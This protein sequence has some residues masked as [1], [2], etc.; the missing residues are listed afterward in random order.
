MKRYQDYLIDDYKTE[1][2][3]PLSEDSKHSKWS[4]VSN[5]YRKFKNFE[6]EFQVNPVT[7]NI[8]EKKRRNKDKYIPQFVSDQLDDLMKDER[9]PLHFRTFYWIARMFPSRLKEI[10]R[11]QV[12]FIK[13]VNDGWV[14]V[15][16]MWKQ[17][18][19]YTESE[20]RTVRLKKNNVEGMFLINLI[21]EQIKC[22]NELQSHLDDTKPKNYLFTARRCSY[23]KLPDNSFKYIEYKGDEYIDVACD[24]SISKFMYSLCE[25]FNITKENGEQYKITSHMLRHTG[26]TDRLSEDFEPV[27][28]KHLTGHKNDSMIQQNYDHT[29]D[30]LL[31][32]KQKLVLDKRE[33]K[34]DT[35]EDKEMVYFNGRIMNMNETMQQ[36]LLRNIRA[37]KVKYGICSDITTCEKNYECLDDCDYFVPDANDLDYFEYEVIQWKKKVEYYKKNNNALLLENAEHNL[38]LHQNVVNKIKRVTK[39]EQ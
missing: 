17:N 20:I 11:L 30:E 32:E 26:I 36:R 23:K 37:H 27:D 16:P 1:K 4:S 29:S 9:I 24:Y 13:K 12:D 8:F 14:L 2:G 31:Q 33:E 3:K 18:G 38:K 10:T 5:F 21:L 19:G 35:I 25:R 6:G 28:I 7:D 22:S 34:Q 15:L 39:V